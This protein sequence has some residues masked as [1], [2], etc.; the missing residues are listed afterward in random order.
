MSGAEDAAWTSAAHSPRPS[1][2]TA[3]CPAWCVRQHAEDDHPEDRYHQS[4]PA[5]VPAVVGTGDAVPVTTTLR[6][7][8]LVVRTGQYADDARV[9]LTVEPLE[10]RRPHVVLTP[11]SARSLVRALQEQLDGLA[12]DQE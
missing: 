7:E 4:E 11:G 1:W 2:L 5:I 10:G 3:P 8:T 9:W 12:P 6:A